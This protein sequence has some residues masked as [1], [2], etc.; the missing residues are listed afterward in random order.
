MSTVWILGGI[1]LANPGRGS[2]LRHEH[3]P[4]ALNYAACLAVASP[5]EENDLLRAAAQAAPI[6]RFR[7]GTVHA[8]APVRLGE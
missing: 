2:P 6:A 5:E 8:A 4:D 3:G 1:M 7:V